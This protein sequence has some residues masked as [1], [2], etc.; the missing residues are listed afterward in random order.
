MLASR[1]PPGTAR[2]TSLEIAARGCVLAPIDVDARRPGFALAPGVMAS[3]S[4]E[5]IGT[6][7]VTFE[8]RSELGHHA[9]F[10]A[11][12]PRAGERLRELIDRAHHENEGAV[13]LVIET[14]DRLA[15]A[16]AQGVGSG[17]IAAEDL[18]SSDYIPILDSDPVQ[19]TTPSLAF[20]ARV[21]PPLLQAARASPLHPLF[22][23]ATDRNAYA[24]VHHP[25][26]SLPQRPGEAGWN[27]L[28]ARD[29]RIYDRGITLAGARNQ[30]RYS[31]R[32]YMRH[33]ADGTALPIQ[34]VAAPIVV[35][36]QFWGNA[37]AGFTL[38]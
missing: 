30:D 14:A 22:V 12:T 9:R 27:D 34:V 32:A 29:R 13:G 25:E 6:M 19:Y 21:L 37:Q 20:C 17:E 8:A 16:F 31:L 18:F 11:L 5:G 2:M 1:R 28:H 3:L 23:L 4:L 33:Q 36:G 10:D 15:Q 26:F 24:P 7:A 35:N 38:P